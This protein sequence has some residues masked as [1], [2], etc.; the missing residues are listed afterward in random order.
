M[1][2]PCGIL[3]TSLTTGCV[4]PCDALGLRDMPSLNNSQWF[5]A[6]KPR[7]PAPRGVMFIYDGLLVY[8]YC[9]SSFAEIEVPLRA[10][11]PALPE[12]N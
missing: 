11:Q 6:V 7:K 10:L 9:G 1:V 5:A 12:P 2:D 4:A 3:D 8:N